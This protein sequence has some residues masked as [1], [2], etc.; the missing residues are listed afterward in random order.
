MFFFD[1]FGLNGLKHFMMQDDKEIIEK[2]LFW[3]EKMTRS[4]KK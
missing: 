1:S 4:D 3:V 2:I